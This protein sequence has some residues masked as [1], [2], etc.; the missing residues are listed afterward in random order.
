[1][2][3]NK[4]KPLSGEQGECLSGSVIIMN[5]CDGAEHRKTQSK[6]VSIVSFSSQLIS[7][8]SIK[9]GMSPASSHNILTWQ[10]M[11]GSETSHNLFPILR[12]IYE[13]K[14]HMLETA[15][16]FLNGCF[17]SF[18]DL[19]D[20]KMSHLLTGHSLHNRRHHPLLLCKCQ[21]GQGCIDENHWCVLIPHEEQIELWDRSKKRWDR[22]TSAD[23]VLK[24]GPHT[25]KNHMD[26][27]DEHNF[28]VSHLGLHP[29]LLRRDNIRFDN[30]HLRCSVTRRLMGNL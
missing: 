3:E 24:K 26:W 12:P 25:E 18:C 20:R 6:K 5:S 23:Q 15:P 7:K 28:G 13:R 8:N 21:R 16:D 10:Q 11:L 17:V 22:R 2:N 1:M 27:I 29:S 9:L 19:H 30:L 14:K 4:E